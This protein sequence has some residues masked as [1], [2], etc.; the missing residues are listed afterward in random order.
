MRT[1]ENVFHWVAKKMEDLVDLPPDIDDNHYKSIID[2]LRFIYGA[3]LGSWLDNI[4]EHLREYEK[5]GVAYFISNPAQLEDFKLEI[6]WL[7]R[8]PKLNDL[9][10][11]SLAGVCQAMGSDYQK[12]LRMFLDNDYFPIRK[13][14]RILSQFYPEE[15]KSWL[16]GLT[17]GE[18]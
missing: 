13:S 8:K 12:A 6:E 10:T 5:H 7:F 14:L 3:L 16:G 4:L 9:F 11:S 2:S 18:D 15:V 17:N 1:P